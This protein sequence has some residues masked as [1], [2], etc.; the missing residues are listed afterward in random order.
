MALNL[1]ETLFQER[2][3]CFANMTFKEVHELV[4]RSSDD[5]LRIRSRLA[6]N[7]PQKFTGLLVGLGG[8]RDKLGQSGHT[9][10]FL[11]QELRGL[12]LGGEQIYENQNAFLVELNLEEL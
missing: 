4:N 10:D 8:T 2:Q 11:P 3:Q 5:L 1:D 12:D 9:F 7:I 6:C